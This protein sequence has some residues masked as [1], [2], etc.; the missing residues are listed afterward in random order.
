[1]PV[2]ASRDAS[3]KAARDNELRW[4]VVRE[5]MRRFATGAKMY[6]VFDLARGF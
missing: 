5:N 3:S 6:A 1:M 2:T 4:I